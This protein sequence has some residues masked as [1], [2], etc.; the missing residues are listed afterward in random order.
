MFLGGNIFLSENAFTSL[1]DSFI[2]VRYFHKS[3]TKS[4]EYK[5]LW[6][7]TKK[8]TITINNPVLCVISSLTNLHFV[9]HTEDCS[10]LCQFLN[11]L[12]NIITI[13]CRNFY[14]INKSC[15]AI[16]TNTRSTSH[17]QRQN[18]SQAGNTQPKNEII[19]KTK[20]EIHIEAGR[21]FLQS[22]IS[23]GHWWWLTQSQ[24]L[25]WSRNTK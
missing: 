18:E 21:W 7:H 11:P 13:K 22:N 17:K 19:L 20:K 2:F 8:L 3:N 9:T 12:I 14:S 24:S 15:W 10:V 25:E 1:L 4:Q 16:L 5:V 6:N 23:V